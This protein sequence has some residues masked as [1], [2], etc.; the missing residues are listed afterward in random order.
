MFRHERERSANSGRKK[1]REGSGV[2]SVP[3][4][5][6]LTGRKD[7]SRGGCKIYRFN[8]S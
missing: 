7:V 2:G 4:V 5:L 1:K 8:A 6:S 3:L